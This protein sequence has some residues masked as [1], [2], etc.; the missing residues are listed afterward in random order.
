MYFDSREARCKTPYGAVPCGTEVTITL[1]P[2][3]DDDVDRAILVAHGEFA[4]SWEEFELSPVSIGGK[5]ALRA[6]YAAP[7]EVEL[8]W[9]HFRLI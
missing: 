1:Y 3:A 2:D 7:K 5:K 4:D 8:V 6:V 9:Y